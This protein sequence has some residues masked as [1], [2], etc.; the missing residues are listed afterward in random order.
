VF[1][2][3]GLAPTRSDNVVQT[4]RAIDPQLRVL[5]GS[6]APWNSDQ[7]GEIV[8][9]HNLPWLNYMQTLVAHIDE[10][11]QARQKHG[12]PLA[13]PDGFALRA[14]G[15]IDAP[16]IA[17]NPATEPASDIHQPDW[18]AAQAGFRVYRDWLAIINRY[19]STR[20]LPA[21]ISSTN[22]ISSAGSTPPAQQ[23]P[24]GWLTAALDEIDREPQV[25]ALCWFVDESLGEIWNDFSLKQHPGQLHDTAEEFERLLQR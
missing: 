20:G 16:E 10:A 15:R 2:G 9:P 25:Q 13:G 6:V 19:P 8:D 1:N 24:A 4:M 22:T 21:Y 11:T 23:Y 5:V 17:A 18:G 14:P 12:I 3:Y 7:N